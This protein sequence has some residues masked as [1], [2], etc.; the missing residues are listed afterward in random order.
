MNL[1]WRAG[2]RREGRALAQSIG[3]FHLG[4]VT[5]DQRTRSR[6]VTATW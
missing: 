4:E 6:R 2:G 5:G 3:G 1:E